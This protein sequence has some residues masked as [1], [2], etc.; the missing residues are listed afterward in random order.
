MKRRIIA[1]AALFLFSAGIYF[2]LYH[3]DKNL[4]FIPENADAVI[5]IDKKKLTKQYLSAFIAHPSQWFD[6]SSDSEKK[7]SV[8]KP[9]L[10]QN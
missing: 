5:L 9:V 6:K 10:Y 3:K 7:R 8:F 4:N 2:L 1:F